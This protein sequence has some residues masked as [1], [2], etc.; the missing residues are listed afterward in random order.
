MSLEI[1]LTNALKHVA[2]ICVCAAL[3]LGC[4]DITQDAYEAKSDRF[5]AAARALRS[6]TPPATF[7]QD[8][9]IL[10]VDLSQSYDSLSPTNM[11]YIQYRD[12]EIEGIGFQIEGEPGDRC[13]H[14]VHR[15][16]ELRTEQGLCGPIRRTKRLEEDWR[17]EVSG[18]RRTP[19]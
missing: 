10:P 16:T 1:T 13:R 19:F 12:G 17:I 11:A 9:G 4:S 8:N 18:R 14:L 5:H 15:V 3:V 2:T 7:E 6:T